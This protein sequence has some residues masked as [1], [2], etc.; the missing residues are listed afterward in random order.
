MGEESWCGGFRS[1]GVRVKRVVLL[2]GLRC[3]RIWEGESAG[4]GEERE[5]FLLLSDSSLLLG[6]RCL[7][8]S[9]SVFGPVRVT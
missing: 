4:S 5:L 6:D 3:R 2:S 7:L 9:L 1:F 8:Y